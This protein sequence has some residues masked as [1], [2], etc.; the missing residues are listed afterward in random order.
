[1]R[2]RVKKSQNPNDSQEA[3]AQQSQSSNMTSLS[4]VGVE[5]ET[6][7]YEDIPNESVEAIHGLLA[8]SRPQ[9]SER[10]AAVCLDK[11]KPRDK[12]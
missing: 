2:V 3:V 1:M 9:T 8:A 12:A 4:V 6:Q 10:L 11:L 5:A 7:G